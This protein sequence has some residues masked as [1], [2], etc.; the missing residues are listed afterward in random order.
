MF[1]TSILPVLIGVSF[2]TLVIFSA[3]AS[4]VLDGIKQPEFEEV[5]FFRSEVGPDGNIHT[6]LVLDDSETKP[7]SRWGVYYQRFSPVGKNLTERE[8]VFTHTESHPAFED[9]IIAVTNPSVL[10]IWDAGGW[11]TDEPVFRSRNGVTGNWTEIGYVL[12]DSFIEQS[13][14][15]GNY[16]V[17]TSDEKVYLAFQRQYLYQTSMTRTDVY[18]TWIT[19]SNLSW[20]SPVLVSNEDH[21]RSESPVLQIQNNHIILLYHDQEVS[22]VERSGGYAISDYYRHLYFRTSN[23]SALT[24]SDPIFLRKEIQERPARYVLDEENHLHLF[25]QIEDEEGNSIPYYWVYDTNGSRIRNG[26]IIDDP[27]SN[28]W[29]NSVY[30]DTHLIVEIRPVR[31]TD[32]CRLNWIGYLNRTGGVENSIEYQFSHLVRYLSVSGIASNNITIMW[33]RNQKVS[34]EWYFLELHLQT[35]SSNGT[36]EEHT[37][38]P[39]PVLSISEDRPRMGDRLLTIYL[40]LGSLLFLLYVSY[41]SQEAVSDSFDAP[42]SSIRRIK[43]ILLLKWLGL[44]MMFPL[45]MILARAEFELG[46][47]M[48]YFGIFV[49]YFTLVI[50]E[51]IVRFGVDKRVRRVHEIGLIWLILFIG[52]FISYEESLFSVAYTKL[53]FMNFL[54]P[55]PYI[56]IISEMRPKVLDEFNS[57]DGRNDPSDPIPRSAD[58]DT[59]DLKFQRFRFRKIIWFIVLTFL[60]PLIIAILVIPQVGG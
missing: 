5:E 51:S 34:R 25:W 21:I 24:W 22:D 6:L 39:A 7:Q 48:V 12:P 52:S 17:A 37:V 42:I 47:A 55:I 18:L 32:N 13:T 31:Y 53:C 44:P 26:T 35:W 20:S 8:Y 41:H 40:I 60:Q 3:Y 14:Q 50:E 27:Y 36:S 2:L 4:N 46:A 29:V 58:L 16:V 9:M 59:L 56:F 57:S 23:D 43:I 10:V 49:C 11:R 45:L 38:D 33:L 19:T 30:L 1:K 54:V 15:L 28:S